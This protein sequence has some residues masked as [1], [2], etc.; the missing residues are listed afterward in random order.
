LYSVEETLGDA[1]KLVDHKYLN[2]IEGLGVPTI[3]NVTI[4]LWRHLSNHLSG[5]ARIELSRGSEGHAEGC[6]YRGA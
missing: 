3:E 6:I 1:R 4:W 5:I 2:D